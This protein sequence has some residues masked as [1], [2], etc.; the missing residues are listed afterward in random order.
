MDKKVQGDDGQGEKASFCRALEFGFISHCAGH[1][2]WV[3]NRGVIWPDSIVKILLLLGVQWSAGSGRESRSSDKRWWWWPGPRWSQ[4]RWWWKMD[5]IV[6]DSE[7]KPIRPSDWMW[8]MKRRRRKEGPLVS[9]KSFCFLLF[10]WF[11]KYCLFLSFLS[12]LEKAMA[13]QSSTLFLKIYF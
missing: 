12:I 6:T 7:V 13:P 10:K 1:H 9:G 8:N 2:W 5:R 3:W 11:I 4:W